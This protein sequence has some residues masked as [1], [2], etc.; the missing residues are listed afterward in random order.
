M[1]DQ[2]LAR[3]ALF[4]DDPY[5]DGIRLEAIRTPSPARAAALDFVFN[6]QRTLDGLEQ[7]YIDRGMH[8]IMDAP[9]C[10]MLKQQG[11]LPFPQK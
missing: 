5:G 10:R 6:G 3:V 4:L 8:A 1:T 7:E 9:T 2:Q 11:L